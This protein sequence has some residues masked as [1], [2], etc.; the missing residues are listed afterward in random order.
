MVTL[1]IK[2]LAKANHI[3]LD[4]QVRN[5]II[6]IYNSETLIFHKKKRINYVNITRLLTRFPEEQIIKGLQIAT[7]SIKNDFFT[8][9]YL[10]R[11]IDKA[12]K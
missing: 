8:L 4:S 7:N 2:T 6:Y 9:S 11:I 12:N 1:C 10:V 3:T 5:L